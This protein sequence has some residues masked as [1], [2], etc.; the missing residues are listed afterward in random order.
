MKKGDLVK[1]SNNGFTAIGF[2]KER[3]A[4]T[5]Y[6]T[7]RYLTI[8]EDNQH[9]GTKIGG[10]WSNQYIKVLKEAQDEKDVSKT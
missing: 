5:Q 10:L 2:I 8:L 1:V 3:T 4:S 9:S 6:Y 7:V